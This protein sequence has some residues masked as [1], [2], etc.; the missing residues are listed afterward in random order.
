MSRS[1]TDPAPVRNGD[2]GAQARNGGMGAEANGESHV[3]HDLREGVRTT[4]DALRDAGRRASEVMSEFGESAYQAGNKTRAQVAGQVEAQPIASILIAASI[5][6]I[7]G[8]L[9]FRR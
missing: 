6:L 7:A 8:A 9:L 1:E 5:G 3:V 4:T 2:M